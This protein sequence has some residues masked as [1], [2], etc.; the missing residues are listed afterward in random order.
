ME[1]IYQESN[2]APAIA[3]YGIHTLSW[4]AVMTGFCFSEMVQS[5]K[6]HSIIPFMTYKIWIEFCCALFWFGFIMVFVG[7]M[8]IIHPHHSV[9]LHWHQ[10]NHTI[11]PVAVSFIQ[12]WCSKWQYFIEK[13][14]L[15]HCEDKR[16]IISKTQTKSA[17]KLNLKVNYGV[18]IVFRENLWC[19][20][21]KNLYDHLKVLQ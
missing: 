14:F 7:F 17:T 18:P 21:R 11:I 4:C 13:I 12:L 2:T 19:Y 1:T 15:F 16:L 9:L 6:S 3:V 5:G 10:G 20:K 8:G